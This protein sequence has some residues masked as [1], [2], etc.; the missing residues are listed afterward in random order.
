M[1]SRDCTQRNIHHVVKYTPSIRKSCNVT[2][3]QSKPARIRR[4]RN[5]NVEPQHLMRTPVRKKC[6]KVW[7]SHWVDGNAGGKI[8][9]RSFRGAAGTVIPNAAPSNCAS[10]GFATNCANCESPS[11]VER[12]SAAERVGVGVVSQRIG[13]F[14]SHVRRIP[15]QVL[16]FR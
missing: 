14:I 3:Q 1:S 7:P 15:L 6:C 4:R 5:R 16:Y 10:C 11:G 2:S 9:T 8:A 12:F 13:E